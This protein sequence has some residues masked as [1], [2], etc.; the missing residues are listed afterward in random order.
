M[1]DELERL[2]NEVSKLKQRLKESEDRF[3]TISHS[4]SNP[5]LITSVEEGRIIDSN[6]ANAKLSGFMREELIGHTTKDAGIWFDSR[7]RNILIKELQANGKVHNLQMEAKARDGRIQ[8]ILL[9]ADP[10]T[11]NSESCLLGIATDIT[12]QIEEASAL[13]KSEARYRALVENSL[14][15]VAIIQKGRILF[16]NK[17]YPDFDNWVSNSL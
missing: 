13:R 10:V 12:K 14:Q 6:E 1:L 4:A 11:V 3:L 5:M 8:T 9:S 16:C 2:R 15:G 17:A 7:N